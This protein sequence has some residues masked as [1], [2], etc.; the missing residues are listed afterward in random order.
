MGWRDDGQRKVWVADSGFSP[1]GYWLSFDQLCTLVV[2]KGYAYST[3]KTLAK[4]SGGNEVSFT[5]EDRKMLRE[6]H[7]ELTY[8]FQSRYKDENGVQS[9][10]RE[11]LVGHNLDDNRKLENI[12]A[13]I[14]PWI[15]DVLVEIHEGV[16]GVEDGE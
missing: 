9:E 11:T 5:E 4:S 8:L 10:Y 3:I 14:L 2:P 15:I 16:K 6:V 7:H 1:Y 12:H 13:D